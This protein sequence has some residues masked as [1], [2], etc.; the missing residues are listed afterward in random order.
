MNKKFT[1]LAAGLMAVSSLT[2]SAEDSTVSVADL[3]TTNDF[4]YLKSG[5][6]KDFC[7]TLDGNKSDSVIVKPFEKVISKAA[8]DSALWQIVDKKVTVG[9]PTYSIR[10]KATLQYLAFAPGE[11]VV[12]NLVSVT[13]GVAHRWGFTNKTLI[14]YYSGE[15]YLALKVEGEKL[16]V[17]TEGNG[18]EFAVEKPSSQYPLNAEELGSGFKTFQIK[19]G[20]TYEGDIF[21]GKDLIAKNGEDGYITLQVKGDLA[22][23]S[24]KAKYLGIDTLKTNI[25][26]AKDVFGYKFSLDSTRQTQKKNEDWQKFKLSIDLKNDSVA[27]FIKAAPESDDS[28][29]VVFASVDNKKVLTVSKVDAKSAPQQG[30]APLINLSAGTHATIPTG[31]GVYFLKSASKGANGGKYYVAKDVYMGGDSVPSVNQPK[32]QWY[33]KADGEKYSVVD[34]E[35][36][37]EFIMNQE[38]FEVTGMKDTYLFGEDSV[39][40]IKQLVNLEDRYLGSLAFTEQE[41]ADKGFALHLIPGTAGVSYLHTYTTDSILK[42]TAETISNEAIFKLIPSDTANVAG[43]KVLG[44]TISVIS[45]KL[46]SLF[47]ADT[48]AIQKDSL[49]LSK[50]DEAT[51]FRFITDATGLKFA[52]LTEDNKYVGMNI[53]T[54]CLQVTENRAYVD[55]VAQEAPEYATVEN[56]YKRFSTNNNSLVMNP[57][58]FFAELKIE[59]NDITKAGYAKDNFSLLVE[60]AENSPVG[61]QL[62]YI[63]CKPIETKADADVRYYLAA[64]DTLDGRAIFIS[65]DSIKTMENSPALFAFKIVEGGGYYLENQSELKKEVVAESKPYVGVANGF[66]IMQS[67]KGAEFTIEAAPAPVANESIEAPNAIKVIG[68]VGEFSIRNAGGKRITLSNIL[69]QT[70]GTRILSSD[71]VS[72]P[73]ARGVVIV[74]VEGDKA[75]KV[76]V[77]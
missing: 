36:G 41:L 48:I 4:F 57:N 21:S 44:D 18:S 23:P 60:K 76:I 52:M 10:N 46:R 2:V 47:N 64:S 43:A 77:K 17:I 32:G 73:V 37:S 6:G 53:N 9:V 16:S 69:G 20:D 11:K 67:I 55:L 22:F 56:G 50:N 66:A 26:G 15:D 71:N 24:G 68:G 12:P 5:S 8:H 70:I 74:S 7:L 30:E 54:S 59:G 42:G 63:S 51:S 28:V 45:Y 29:R 61:K 3:G 58:T 39:T 33:I 75:Y 14:S 40:V 31:T 62:Y 65:H 1:L 49:K 35:S 13:D 19:F 27:M 72:V 38:I 25:S 34:R